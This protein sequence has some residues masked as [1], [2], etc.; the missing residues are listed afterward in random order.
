MGVRDSLLRKHLSIPN[1]GEIIS[2]NDIRDRNNNNQKLKAEELTALQNYENF[3]LRE[4]NR[5][6]NDDSFHERYRELQ[7]I[8]NLGDYREFLKEK[9]FSEE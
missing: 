9:Y 4:L 5:E 7:V 3:R 1:S 8:A 2:I 6:S